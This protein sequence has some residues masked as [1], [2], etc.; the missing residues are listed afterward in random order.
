MRRAG[1][2]LAT[3]PLAP[4]PRRPKRLLAAV[5]SAGLATAGMVV[6][7]TT[8]AAVVTDPSPSFEILPSDLEFILAQIKISESHAAGNPLLCAS[9][10]DTSGTCVP[11]PQLPWGLRTVDGSF[12]NLLPGQSRFGSA[13]Q[14]MTRLLDI[15]LRPGVG[16]APP[17]GAPT[18]PGTTAVCT[19]EFATPTCYR[20]TS[21]FVYDSHPRV[22]SNLIVDQTTG[23]P[24]AVAVAGKV[25]GSTTAPDGRLFIP[26]E[27]PD[28]GLSA[29]YNTWMTFFGQFFD[30]GL[31]LVSKGGSGSVVVP[32][33]HDDPLYDAGVDGI[34]GTPDDGR[35]NFLTLTRATNKPGPDG[36]LGTADDVRD[37]TNRTTPFVDQNQTYTS[38]PSH[39]AFLREYAMVDGRPVAT[40]QLLDSPEGGLATWADI[41]AQAATKLGI[42]LSDY[43]VVNV[44]LLR[45][46]PYGN[47]VPGANGLP[48]IATPTG[49]VDASLVSPVAPAS[50]GALRANHAFL[51]DIAHAASPFSS[52]GDRLLR[53]TRQ[54]LLDREPV[55]DG[56]LLDAHFMTGDGRGNE[57]I[58]LT[59]VH[60]V[61]HA[62][63]NRVADD[64]ARILDENP[65]LKARYETEGANRW[66]Y[67]VRLFHAA[68][69]VT[70]MEY[71]HLVFEEF[72]R[73]IAPFIDTVPNNESGYHTDLNAAITAEFAHVVYRFG[74]SMLTET[75][76]RVGAE[77]LSLL[78]AFLNPRAFRC[79]V[80]P[81]DVD[82]VCAVP[83]MTPEEAAGS[84]VTGMVAHPGSG[85]DEFVTETLRN[86][87]LGL[88]LDLAAINLMRG[89]DA[90]VPSLQAART[91][92]FDVTG[93]PDLEPYAHWKAFGTA[94]RNPESLVNFIAAYGTH[95][96]ILTDAGPDGQLADDPG[97]E[98]DETADNGR[99]TVASRRAAAQALVAADDAFLTAPAAQS[100]LN[101]VD[102]WMGGLAE[103]NVPFAGFLGTTFN[104]V[105]ETQLESLQNG[106]RFYY[107]S[108][109]IGLNLFHQLEANSFSSI[110]MRTTD[111]ELLPA[112]I[113]ATPDHTFDLA[114]PQP[115]WAGQGMTFDGTEW[116]YVGD[117]HVNI[118]GTPG[119]DRF[120]GGIG[121]DSLWG[122]G[123]DDLITGGAG[124]NA[125]VGGA[126]SDILHGLGGD[127]NLKGGRGDDALNGGSGE[128]LL[129]GGSGRDF[130]V[131]PL[132]LS[133]T[134]AGTGD[135]LV[136]GGPAHDQI[137]GNE[138]DDWL[139]GGGGADLVQG[140][141]ANGFQNDPNGGHDVLLGGPG[142]DDLDTEG[143][144]DTIVASAG[145][146][147]HEGMLGFDWV[148][149]KGDP[150][151][152]DAD[153]DNTVFQPPTSENFRD[154]YDLVEGLSGWNLNDVLRGKGRQDEGLGTGEGHELTQAHLDRVAGLRDLLGGGA[155]PAYAAPFMTAGTSNDII[156]GGTGS[157]LVEGRAGDDFIDGSASLN[158]QLRVGAQ[159][160]DTL[161]Q[162]RTAVFAGT[163]RPGDIT[164]VREILTATDV[165]AINTA[166]YSGNRAD[167]DLTEITPGTWRVFHARP[168]GRPDPD[169]LRLSDGTDVL[170][171]I[172]RLAFA[173]QTVPV[174][175]APNNLP[176]G[177]V[178]LAVLPPR[179]GVQLTVTDDVTDADGISA[180]TRRYTWQVEEAGEW[181]AA[182]GE[183]TTS[184]GGV[185]NDRYV[186]TAA[187]AGKRLRV[188]YTYTDTRSPVG[189]LE[190]VTSQ[191]TD[192]VVAADPVPVPVA[193]VSPGAL[194]F[195]SVVVGSAPVAQQVT[196]AN[197][198]TGPLLVSAVGLTGADA[199]Q[200]RFT[201]ACD[202]VAPGGSCT[203][204]VTFTPTTAGARSASLTVTHDAAGAPSTVALTG[205]GVAPTA[206]AVSV[207]ASLD[208]GT[209]RVGQTRSANLRV[210]NTGNAPLVIGALTVD[211]MA[212]PFTA[213]RG[214]CPASL[215]PGRSCN[216]AVSFR[217]T[218][219]G[220]H[221][222]GL[223]ISSNAPG[224][225]ARV[226][227]R[228]TGR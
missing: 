1:R 61:F 219:A 73:T 146:D 117:A 215:A 199:T 191:A 169:R 182:T 88:P 148:T 85:I 212:A 24:A 9:P 221:T 187:D 129:L 138:G 149:H 198:G 45:T 101:S 92:F 201:T 188:V 157:D 125:V 90:G 77:E 23:N 192:P 74:H 98:A 224:V 136:L 172:Q 208:L 180:T 179:E 96:T 116:R 144:D 30:H 183:A 11:H 213:A 156:L 150:S 186:P 118:H 17:A 115:D 141:N 20:Q 49:F 39:Q 58:G 112:E 175:D 113:F 95:P 12:N 176:A 105:F 34:A 102:F 53:G 109:N 14:P 204:D 126:G 166:V 226:T 106:D 177:T 152:A 108:R 143:G 206:P 190:Q 145:T 154:R 2:E 79:P 60:H 203:V 159:R 202:S 84:V 82:G 8:A 210:T 56:D 114:N 133:S 31:D 200:F 124:A 218:S 173:D 64:I 165:G 50:A 76:H 189:T 134:F 55:F 151:A 163:I 153:M 110:I 228:G 21:G 99:P 164:V 19:G 81:Q 26:N 15:D 68:R 71:Q 38:H 65:A 167:Y 87:L 171:N 51:D 170:R 216:L 128:D 62:E 46:D 3:A 140:D 132:D 6:A 25:E 158:A 32:L 94:L 193:S 196:V 37:H 184:P 29:P 80:L 42:A 161:D 111:A 197:T 5:L 86:E 121:D 211:P 222:A 18:T 22:T 155:N 33:Q 139:E 220:V 7:P 72:G 67:G 127:D 16:E 97:T 54:Q 107:L 162:L 93:D 195:G 205:T 120:R 47:L 78:D 122:H 119:N 135:D 103:R 207:A 57:N 100:G 168:G 36:V 63:H 123:G 69:Y 10:T 70:E 137:A 174:A 178:T 131:N 13:D 223:V 43:D 52:R 130:V 227:L 104:H 181:S 27:A 89:R 48:Q 160:F 194:A 142:N 75:V 147:R 209:A 185:T 41:K 28:E 83:L 91:R 40:G 66:A 225:P 217:P 59:A 44:P 4:R 35:L 214:T